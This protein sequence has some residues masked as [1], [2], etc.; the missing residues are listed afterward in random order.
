MNPVEKRYIV[1]LCEFACG[2][3][4]EN[5]EEMNLYMEKQ[6]HY[7]LGISSCHQLSFEN[8]GR[9][10]NCHFWSLFLHFS[11]KVFPSSKL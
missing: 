11:V 8:E 5:E 2:E 1:I 7:Y 6:N 4:F 10:T 3:A 9:V